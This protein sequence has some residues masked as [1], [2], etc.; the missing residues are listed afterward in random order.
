M[1]RLEHAGFRLVAALFRAMPLDRASAVSGRI[2]RFVA[3]WLKRHARARANLMAAMPELDAGQ[4]EAILAEMW[5]VLG[6]TFGEAFHL[7]DFVAEP[8]RI[9]VELSPEIAELFAGKQGCVM[10]SMHAGNWE[11]AA[12]AAAS[13]GRP[14]AGIYQSLKNPLVDRDVTALR[15]PFYP[16]GLFSKAPDTVMRLMRIVRGGGALA[17][18]A[19][20]RERRG[21]PAPFFGRPAPSTPFPA[22]LARACNVPLIA[23]RVRRLEGAHFLVTAEI[24]PVSRSA[25]READVRDAT[26]ALQAVFERW[27]RETPGQWMWGHRRWAR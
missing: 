23:A 8:S 15:A 2:W 22:L 27:I 7:A 18:L 24:V 4:R 20:L 14:I 19:D 6:R 1:A 26:E 17:V 5:E 10:A 25:D 9:R 21:V 3:P 12:L 16:L 11:L 13:V